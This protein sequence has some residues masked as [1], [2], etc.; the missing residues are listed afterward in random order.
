MMELRL[1]K[2]D[3]GAMG[4]IIDGL[5]HLREVNGQGER[6][7]FPIIQFSN[8]HCVAGGEVSRNPSGVQV[9]HSLGIEVVKRE[10]DILRFGFNIAGQE[11]SEADSPA[12]LI[13]RLQESVGDLKPYVKDPDA[14][15]AATAK[16]IRQLCNTLQN[17]K[18]HA[19][20]S[21]TPE[22]VIQS[23][24]LAWREFY[25]VRRIVDQY[26]KGASFLRSVP[27]VPHVSQV[28][29][30]LETDRPPQPV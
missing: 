28:L 27:N 4:A 5:L 3:L 29:P 17:G 2:I 11:R 6:R 14:V 1:A 18:V 15:V 13:Q 21:A 16:I 9:R 10:F 30:A 24:E 22:P 19:Q 25:P 7:C 8:R 20:L 26:L 12:P 23:D